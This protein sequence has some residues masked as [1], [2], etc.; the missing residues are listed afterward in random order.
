MGRE[1]ETH[2]ASTASSSGTQS[3]QPPHSTPAPALDRHQGAALGPEWLAKSKLLDSLE[4]SV[5]GTLG[6]LTIHY[7][8]DVIA[9]SN[10]QNG[11]WIQLTDGC[12]DMQGAFTKSS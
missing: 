3:A 6:C 4:S 8:Q 1:N 5:K 7:E 9:I 10:G 12:S 11:E 2:G